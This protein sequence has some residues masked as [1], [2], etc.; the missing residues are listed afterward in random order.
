[1]L[2]TIVSNV[3][4]I[5]RDAKVQQIFY[6]A[7]DLSKKVQKNFILQSRNSKMTFIA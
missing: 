6:I 2:I 7:N 5:V 1:M 3:I 4:Y